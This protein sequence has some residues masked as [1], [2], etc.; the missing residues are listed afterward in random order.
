[1]T[2]STWP[3]QLALTGQKVGQIDEEETAIMD[4]SAR[5]HAIEM[6]ADG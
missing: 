6:R 4:R 5:F 2:Q 1:V 3:E